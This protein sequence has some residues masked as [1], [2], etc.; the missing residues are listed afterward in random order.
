MPPTNTPASAENIF[1]AK[2]IAMEDPATDPMPSCDSAI[3]K[4]ERFDMDAYL[5]LMTTGF[6]E[7]RI[8]KED[9]K[10]LKSWFS[11]R[12][13]G[14]EITTY[15]KT[16]STSKKYRFG[17]LQV[18][19]QGLSRFSRDV[20][21]ALGAKYY[22]DLDMENSQ[23]R[24]FVQFCDKYEWKCDAMRYY[25]EHR[26]EVLQSL[27]DLK[28]LTR[29]DAKEMV[30]SIMYGS[31]D[32]SD[33]TD[34]I[35]N[36]LFPECQRIMEKVWTHTDFAP[37]VART[38]TLKDK[39]NPK[40]KCLS[41]VLQEIEKQCLMALDNCLQK[42]GRSGIQVLMHDGGFLEKLVKDGGVYEPDPPVNLIPICEQAIKDAT[43]Y[44]VV[45]AFKTVE[46]SFNIH[47]DTEKYVRPYVKEKTY[48]LMKE[49]FEE[50]HFYLINGGF[51]CQERED[52]E[53]YMFESVAKAREALCTK[54]TWRH[55]NEEE[56]REHIT[57]FIDIWIED[58][59]RRTIR[60]LVFVPTNAP[61]HPEDLNI[62]QGFEI[63]NRELN[64]ETSLDKYHDHLRLLS[65]GNAEIQ[66]YITKWISHMI[67]KPEELPE[68]MLIFVGKQGC[69]KSLFWKFIGDCV[70]G[71]K[72]YMMTDNP[73]EDIFGKHATLG[74]GKLL[75]QM[76]E[77][78]SFSNRANA[79]RL[80]A[81]I[82][83]D[84][85]VINPKG[86][87]MYKLNNY[88]RVVGSSNETAPVK[89]EGT[90]R[91][92]VISYVSDEKRY[93]KEHPENREFWNV[94]AKY[95][96]DPDTARAVFEF[97][98]TQ[99]I[100]TFNVRNKVETEYTEMLK[101]HEKPYEEQFIDSWDGDFTEHRY[102]FIY[103]DAEPTPDADKILEGKSSELY[104]KYR[105]W[106]EK[107]GLKAVALNHFGRL[108]S[109]LVMTGILKTRKKDGITLYTKVKKAE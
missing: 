6:E 86:E 44:N 22:W 77:M 39:T 108:M 69:G 76:E 87:K 95:Y 93:S 68:V 63:A 15:Y 70:V 41:T 34:F 66:D 9:K 102:G 21:G 48:L 25:V 64:P 78:S 18:Q 40:G 71:K 60:Q 16:A 10:H 59:K 1:S 28:K 81:K 13:S 90:D 24:L 103:E 104:Q 56:K 2:D 67:Q 47:V 5:W 35:K 98:R 94:M 89:V 74:Q 51:I 65:G 12:K 82:T 58:E 62:W 96:A 7:G 50:T 29:R 57:H 73:D 54:W 23:P 33:A 83:Q 92:F 109:P 46:T 27:M 88:K 100:S 11:E 85:E 38:K 105:R 30:I 14:N 31:H 75:V 99:D 42:N 17:R 61:V 43:T 49:R 36:Q 37:Y 53:L 45:L 3:I 79:S 84:V 20:R 8:T 80:K 19:G 52:G 106:C 32:V 55:Y 101:E 107:Q 4:K 72:A 91:R 97:H 26:A